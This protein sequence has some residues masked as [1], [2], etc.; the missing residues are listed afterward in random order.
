[1]LTNI[2]FTSNTVFHFNSGLQDG[3][4]TVVFFSP[5]ILDNIDRWRFFLE[6]SVYADAVAMIAVDEAHLLQSW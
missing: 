4:Y 3:S 2:Y 5:E 1:M 6:S